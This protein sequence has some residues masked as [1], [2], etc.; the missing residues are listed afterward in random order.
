MLGQTVEDI[1]PVLFSNIPFYFW[2]K[3]I[4]VILLLLWLS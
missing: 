2:I 3:V 4:K 1:A